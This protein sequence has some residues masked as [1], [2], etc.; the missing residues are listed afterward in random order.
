M[1]CVVSEVPGKVQSILPCPPDLVADQISLLASAFPVAAAKTGMLFSI[2][3]IEAAAAALSPVAA[4]LVVDPVMVATS[5]DPLLED[6]AASA[7][8]RLIF[9]MAAVITPNLDEAA[10]LLG[11]P[12]RAERELADAAKALR[13]RYGCAVL[14]KGGHLRGEQAVDVLADAAGE[15]EFRAAFVPGVSTHG[16][17]CTYSA[18]IAAHLAKGESLREAVAGAKRYVTA[19]VAGFHR[20][21]EVDALDHFALVE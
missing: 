20:W 21:G 3:H 15:A 11:Y 14:L 16:T 1:T 12:I 8:E 13:D 2:P 9:P 10:H 4:P 7:Y 5:G 17:G 18:A 6:G 19:A